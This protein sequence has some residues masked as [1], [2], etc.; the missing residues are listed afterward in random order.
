MPLAFRPFGESRMKITP[1]N[2]QALGIIPF[3]ISVAL[4][5][6]VAYHSPQHMKYF[7]FMNVLALAYT[8]IVLGSWIRRNLSE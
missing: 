7:L 2:I 6:F 5:G 4:V 3:W 8:M 1:Y